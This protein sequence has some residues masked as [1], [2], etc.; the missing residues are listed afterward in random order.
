MDKR[1]I[2]AAAQFA[3][4]GRIIDIQEYGR[5]NVNDTFLVTGR[6]A[7]PASRRGAPPALNT[8]NIGASHE[9]RLFSLVPKL[10]LGNAL[11][12]KALLCPS[13]R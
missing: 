7:H 10:P 11:V 5:G 4:S 9:C 3:L 2:T 13:H 6:G 1:L 8:K 12:S